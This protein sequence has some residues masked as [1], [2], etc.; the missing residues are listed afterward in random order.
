MNSLLLKERW[1]ELTQFLKFY[2]KASNIYAVHSP[3]AFQLLSAIEKARI[4]STPHSYKNWWKKLK[5]NKR[6]LTH[7]DLGAGSRSTS[8][9]TISRAA[10]I[11]SSSNIKTELITRIA[12]CSNPKCILELG[13][14]LGKTSVSLAFNCNN[15]K[16]HT[17][18]SS[19]ELC[20]LAYEAFNIL[21]LS[22]IHCYNSTF[23]SF[24]ENH[25]DVL[26]KTDFIFIDG[27]HSYEA[28][29]RNFFH[30]YSHSLDNAIIVIDDIYWSEG[31]T[32]A[33]RNITNSLNNA[34]IIDFF[35]IGL[36]IKNSSFNSVYYSIL[37]N[38]LKPFSWN[39]FK[40]RA[41]TPS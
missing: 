25:H 40:P 33:W 23:T 15:A 41:Y 30:V 12:K 24:F 38:Y 35:Q 21:D 14:N 27:D 7:N 2:W 31:M 26:L 11:S 13:T 4:N 36:I 5:S 17:V 29:I 37:P 16:V 8:K 32:K 18:E 6:I 22:N 1:H 39:I 9:N 28:T 19:S 34:I 10:K 20:S 3:K